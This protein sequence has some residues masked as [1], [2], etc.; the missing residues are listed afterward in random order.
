MIVV[1]TGLI[2]RSRTTLIVAENHVFRTPE[3]GCHVKMG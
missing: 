3:K 2:R 1:D